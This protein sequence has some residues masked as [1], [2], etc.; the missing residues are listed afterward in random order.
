MSDTLTLYK[1]I[2]LYMLDKVSFPMS[3]GQ[4][5]EFMLDKEYTDYFTVQTI[6]VTVQGLTQDAT[7]KTPVQTTQS[8]FPVPVMTLHL[9]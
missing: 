8:S 1:L 6:E 3:N 2:L 7:T 5:S 4:L 9:S